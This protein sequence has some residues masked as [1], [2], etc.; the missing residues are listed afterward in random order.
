MDSYTIYLGLS[1]TFGRSKKAVFPFVIKRIWKKLEG[2]KEK[3]QSRFGNETLIKAIAQVVPNYIMSCY[4]FPEGTC[5]DIEAMI[6]NFWWGSSDEAR[7]VHWLSQD[8]MTEV[9]YRGGVGFRGFNDFN[10][11]LLSKHRWRLMSKE[12]SLMEK[13]FKTKYYTRSTFME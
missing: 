5:H 11:A 7:K 6:A 3:C 2:Q 4:K 12:G 13:I 8:K 10:K 9:K 1:V